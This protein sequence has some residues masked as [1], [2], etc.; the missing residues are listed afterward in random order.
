MFERQNSEMLGLVRPTGFEPVA[1]GLGIRCSIL[2]SYG[3]VRGRL[4]ERAALRNRHHNLADLLVRFEI[5]V[6][7]N[8][9]FQPLKFT[10]DDWLKVTAR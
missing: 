7:F 3:R 2:L 6:R 1:P 10:G 8:K 9:A 5:S 4:G